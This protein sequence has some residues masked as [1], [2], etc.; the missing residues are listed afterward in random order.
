MSASPKSLKKLIRNEE[1][2]M[3]RTNASRKKQKNHPF[4]S[5]FKRTDDFILHQCLFIYNQVEVHLEEICGFFAEKHSLHKDLEILSD[6]TVA[7]VN[8]ELQLN[9]AV[10]FVD[11]KLRIRH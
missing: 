10:L 9:G 3:I 7:S 6:L 8:A 11:L 5:F 2:N 4:P 1:I